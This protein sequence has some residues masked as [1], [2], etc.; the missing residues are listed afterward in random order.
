MAAHSESLPAH[1]P[2]RRLGVSGAVVGALAL[3]GVV[4]GAL[5]L[6]LAGFGHEAH[7]RA[8]HALHFNWLFWSSVAMG[9]VIF[10]MALHIT[11]SRWSWS[12]RRFA[13]AGVS[14]LPVSLLLFIPMWW[15]S[16]HYFHHW[17]G[18][19]EG[20]PVLEEKAAWLSLPGMAVRDSIGVLVLYGLAIWFAYH[21]LRTDAYGV[22]D[23][24]GIYAWLT[25]GFRGIPEEPVRSR[26]INL[27][28][29][30]I[31]CILFAVLWGLVAIDQAMTML[32][33]WFSTMFPVTFLV[34]AFH[35]AIAMTAIVATLVRRRERLE[36]YVTERQYHDLGKLLFAFAVFWM[37]VN[38]SQY[39]VIWY[40]LLP[41]EQEWFVKRFNAPFGTVTQ[42]AVACIFVFPFL[43]LLTRPPKKVPG[44]LAG[45]A[46]VIL[47]GHWLERFLITVPSVWSR[48]DLDLADGVAVPL[49][50][51][52]PE[53]L[54]ALG[55]AG[56]FAA[57]IVWFLR[58]FPILPSPA[59]LAAVPSPTIHVPAGA[60]P[61]QQAEY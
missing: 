16:E 15:G 3:G 6:L 37:Y 11:N 53:I 25:K 43:A 41:H 40:G 49:P 20:D 17:L 54:V 5:G 59:T 56:L 39:V 31:T 14:F 34:S 35:S 13:V 26:N 7:G 2:F 18:H 33:H 50:L 21:A 12:I 8:W 47:I 29:A 30:P 42:V 45:V 23:G 44:V 9:M 57:C 55:F 22:K 52:L 27:W 10:A 51:G 32:P 58:T 61:A 24:G 38:W 48:D 60:R 36:D 4:L 19:I 1:I 28:I 46:A